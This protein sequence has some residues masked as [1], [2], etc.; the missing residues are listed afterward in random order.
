MQL[1][2]SRG[3]EVSVREQL[4]TQ[5]RL[6]IL[7][8]DLAPGQRLPSVRELARRFRLHSNTISAGYRQLERENWVKSR[9]GSGVYVC[10]RKPDLPTS[11]AFALDRLIA[12]LVQSA[13]ALGVPIA[14]V[15][16]GLRQ[17]L[18]LQR[19]TISC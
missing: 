1:W 12:R 13:R 5:V 6:G 10:D 8:D 18:E 16:S 14:T 7:S 11:S 3:S 15:R 19:P 2:L 17:W 9:R 4:V